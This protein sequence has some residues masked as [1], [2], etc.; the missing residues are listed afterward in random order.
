[1]ALHDILFLH[2]DARCFRAYDERFGDRF[3][4]GGVADPLFVRCYERAAA[5]FSPGRVGERGTPV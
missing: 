5:R 1:M 3:A 4:R 2:Q